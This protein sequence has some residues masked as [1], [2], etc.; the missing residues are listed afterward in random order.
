MHPH[1]HSICVKSW[2]YVSC[3]IPFYLP[4]QLCILSSLP[5]T[6]MKTVSII[7]SQHL[8]DL[9]NT[10]NAS[11]YPAIYISLI[12][13][14]RTLEISMCFERIF[15]MVSLEWA[16]FKL[17]KLFSWFYFPQ[18]EISVHVLTI[19]FVYTYINIYDL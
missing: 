13:Y 14:G 5:V 15:I 11:D 16:I 1:R 12:I 6:A 17:E 8:A 10:M 9:V 4:P 2:V 3:L 7:T 19:C 18:I